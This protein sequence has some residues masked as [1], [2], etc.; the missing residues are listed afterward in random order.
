VIRYGVRE[1]VRIR[2]NEMVEEIKCF[3]CWGVGHFKWECP[4][5]EV[6][7]KRKRDEEAVH[8]ASPQKAQQ[9]E[10][11]VHPLWRKVQEYS[12]TQRM[13]LRSAALEQRG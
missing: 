8:M 9:G 2:R 6:E 10:I 4:N 3:R 7:K 11:P 5:I 12:S 1:E 13:P